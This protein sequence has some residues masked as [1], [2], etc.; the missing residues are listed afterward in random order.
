MIF[1]QNRKLQWNRIETINEFMFAG[2]R[3]LGTL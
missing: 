1:S 3:N 2:L